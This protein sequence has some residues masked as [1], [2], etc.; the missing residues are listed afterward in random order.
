MSNLTYMEDDAF[1]NLDDKV[2]EVDQV[3]SILQMVWRITS[4]ILKLVICCCSAGAC[5]FLIYIISK[6]NKLRRSQN[7]FVLHYAIAY[8]IDMLVLPLLV[9]I[10]DFTIGSWS[11]TIRWELM[12]LLY[13][14][15]G[16]S[17]ILVFVFGAT[18]GI[19]WFIE[20]VKTT[21]FQNLTNFKI[22]FI[23]AIYLI[24]IIKFLIFSVECFFET[25]STSTILI[26]TYS[27]LLV[28]IIIINIAVKRV[29]LNQDQLKSKYL[30][31]ISTYITCSYLPLLASSFLLNFDVPDPVYYV[32]NF[33]YLLTECFAFSGIIVVTYL[34]GENNKYFKTAY[35]RVFKRSVKSYDGSMLNDDSE[36][37]EEVEDQ[38]S[39]SVNTG[40]A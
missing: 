4:Q 18:I 5:V 35:N 21:W 23:V 1:I 6:F 19:Y 12:C 22:Y 10:N 24:C 11:G 36:E 28:V 30:L 40:V 29:E 25:I 20:T 3:T 37:A 39:E 31:T 15:N 32:L 9:L 14:I 13:V 8:S 7:I 17:Y 16:S 2:V 33:T 27:T 26:V 34:L 38:V